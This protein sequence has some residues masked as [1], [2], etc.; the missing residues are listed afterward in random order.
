M[1]LCY[2]FLC[3]SCYITMFVF[4][5]QP[6]LPTAMCSHQPVTLHSHRPTFVRTL[7]LLSYQSWHKFSAPWRVAS[8]TRYNSQDKR[9]INWIYIDRKYSI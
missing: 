1:T 7:K 9:A 6:L 2:C 8:R 3:C 5:S 4:I